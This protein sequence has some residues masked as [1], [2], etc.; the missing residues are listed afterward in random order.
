MI[1]GCRRR[2]GG[3]YRGQTE[4]G[5]GVVARRRIQFSR[6]FTLVELLLVII[7]VALLIALALP[8]LSGSISSARSLSCRA[9]LKSLM[10]AC[11]GYLGDHSGLLPTAYTEVNIVAGYWGPIP[12]LAEYL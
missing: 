4:K 2:P 3:F 10:T 8:S 11:H 9:N 5:F 12:A 6:A 7:I 1:H